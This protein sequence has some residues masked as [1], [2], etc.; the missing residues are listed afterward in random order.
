MF[1]SSDI[2][3]ESTPIICVL[4]LP[5]LHLHIGP[6]NT[7]YEEVSRRWDG[8][9][10]WINKL[11]VKREEYHGGSFNGNDSRKLLKNIKILEDLAPPKFKRYI[12]TS[13]TFNEVAHACCG[14]TLSSDY[15]EKIKRFRISYR[16]LKI[17]ITPKVHSVCFHISEFCELV[18]M[19]L[20]PWGEQTCESIHSDFKKIWENYKIKS[21][22]HGDYAQRLLDAIINY[23]SQHL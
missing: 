17:S 20:G 10:E 15:Q 13:K 19:G 23:N 6:V 11:D 7:L 5:E 14:K 18:K 8:I 16:R 22:E 2:F 9:E 1:A 21:T 12:D 4:P 3:D